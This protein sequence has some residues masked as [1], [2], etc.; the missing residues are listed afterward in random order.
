[1]YGGCTRAHTSVIL[2]GRQTEIKG[3]PRDS[4]QGVAALPCCTAPAPLFLSGL[5]IAVKEVER[6]GGGGGGGFLF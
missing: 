6:G 1:M 5:I 4:S 2:G 3:D